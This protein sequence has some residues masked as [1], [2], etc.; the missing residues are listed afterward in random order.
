MLKIYCSLT[1]VQLFVLYGTNNWSK[2]NSNRFASNRR[3]RE[4]FITA[5]GQKVDAKAMLTDESIVVLKSSQALETA[6]PSLS[7]GLTKLRNNLEEKGMLTPSGDRLV[8]AEDILF[9]TASQAAA[10]PLGYPCS[11]PDYWR[12]SSG[13]TLKEIETE[14]V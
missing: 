13:K 12:D 3:A 2:N 14:S 11:G 8:A 7:K 5:E 1:F 4:H 10:V 6:Q 9:T